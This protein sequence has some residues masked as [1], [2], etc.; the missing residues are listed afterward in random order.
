MLELLKNL[1]KTAAN[2]NPVVLLVPGIILLVVG[3]FIWLGGMKFRK[4]FSAFIGGLAGGLGG[5]LLSGRNPAFGCITAVVS[6]VLA[7]LLKRIFISVLAA[8]IALAIGYFLVA[9]PYIK[10]IQQSAP[11][12][13]ILRQTEQQA[14]L[15]I[16]KSM[17]EIRNWA[18]QT[19]ETIRQAASQIPWY[20]WAIIAL[21]VALFI[22]ASVLLWRVIAAF[23]C[24]TIG[25]S[26]I[27]AGM[28]FLLLF[29][30]SEPVSHIAGRQAF[31]LTVFGAMVAFGTAEQS[32][33]VT[34]KKKGDASLRQLKK[35]LE[36]SK[37]A[38]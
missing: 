12:R 35:K 8:I 19:T 34:F 16:T 7:L 29:K 1:E 37:T 24:S 9:K 23:C 17:R 4:S 33:L 20:K 3:L 10:D 11:A 21:A 26:L 14:R 36:D 2:L 27:F 15:S 5:Y 25:T 31:Y 32:I 30:G 6:M 38:E 13:R 18:G 22:F 28:I